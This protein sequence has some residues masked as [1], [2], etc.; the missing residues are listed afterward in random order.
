MRGRKEGVEGENGKE[1]KN[2][3]RIKSR[4]RSNKISVSDLI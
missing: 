2:D 1:N 3:C 4:Y